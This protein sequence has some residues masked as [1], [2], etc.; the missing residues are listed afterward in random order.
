MKVQLT[1]FLPL[2][3]TGLARLISSKQSN[4]M[5]GTKFEISQRMGRTL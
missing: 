1:N 5:A 2:T 4:E 3:G